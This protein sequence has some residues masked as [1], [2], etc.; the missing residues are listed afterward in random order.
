[1]V[2]LRAPMP[3]L[4]SILAVVLASGF[5]SVSSAT[6][7]AQ[8][9]DA[10]AATES[11]STKSA[12]DPAAAEALFRAGRQLLL[13]SKP[14][15][16]FA[17]FEE[18]YRLDPTA[19]AIFNQG[20]CRLKQGKTASAW[21]LFQQA[22]TLADVQGK[23]DLFELATSRTNELQSDLSYVTFHVS[24][25]VPGLE[26]YRDGVLVGP[27]QFD[28]SLPI[29]PGRH[30][31][32]ARAPG[33]ER[34][35]LAVIVGDKHD[36]RT[37]MIPQLKEKPLPL[38]PAMPP[39]PRPQP[40][41][42]NSGEPNP[43][44]WILGAAGATSLIIGTVSGLLALHENQKMIDACPTRIDCP[45]GVIVAQGRRNL[46]SDIAWVTIP[47]G[48]IAL[49]GAATWLVVSQ[50]PERATRASRTS[51]TVDAGSNGRH[52]GLNLAGAF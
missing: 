18:S 43:G 40:P 9:L 34:L 45:R 2:R 27:A 32:S 4:R 47:V 6:S 7:F 31:I 35:E 33:Y 12:R 52:I 39:P 22:A 23:P 46:E 13:E 36:R 48:L 49:G 28:V 44:P 37:V 19:G 24:S 25:A 10:P 11:P 38:V 14:D 26:V 8:T 17:K 51:L 50:E 29:D 15:E 1:V 21:A 20:E 42:K 3:V 41:P 30:A 5:A 16:A